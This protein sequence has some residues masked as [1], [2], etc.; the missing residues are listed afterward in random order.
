MQLAAYSLLEAYSL[1]AIRDC[2]YSSYK[3]QL[4]ITVQEA[5]CSYSA[6]I[7]L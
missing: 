7:S 5:A 6:F 2:S 1:C 3:K 4:V